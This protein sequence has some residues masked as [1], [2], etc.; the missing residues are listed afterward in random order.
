MLSAASSGRIA[1]LRALHL[2]DLLC[3][4]PALRS[5]RSAYPDAEITLI[6][7]PWAQEFAARFGRLVDEFL[8]FPGFPG[9]PEETPRSKDIVS[10]LLTCQHEP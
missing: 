6:G 5:L 2:G 1:V 4:V 7:L 8:P 10:F 9:F 3:A